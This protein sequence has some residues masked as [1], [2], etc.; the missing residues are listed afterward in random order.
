MLA[1]ALGGCRGERNAVTE[2]PFEFTVEEVFYIKP[3]VDRVILVGTVRQGTL[4]PGDEATVHCAGGPVSVVIEGIE[5][6][7]K[8]EAKEARKGDQVG[9]R[10]RG[11]TKDQPARNDRVTGSGPKK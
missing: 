8:G 6:F 7:Q 1:T 10:M 5:S 4:R 3:P 9:L 11:I 2:T